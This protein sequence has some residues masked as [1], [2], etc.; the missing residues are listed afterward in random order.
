MASLHLGLLGAGIARSR[1]PRLQH[2][3]GQLVNTQIEYVL[4]DGL[5]QPAFDAKACVLQAIAD[6]FQGLNVTHPYKQQIY[7]LVSSPCIPA[8]ERIG[9]Y[10]TLLFRGHQILGANTDYSGFIRAYLNKFGNRPPGQVFLCGAGGV[11]RAVAMGLKALGCKKIAIFDT[12]LSQAESL[13]GLLE[14]EAVSV[15][16]VTEQ[17]MATSVVNADGLV[18]CTA[19]GMYHTPGSAIDLALVSKQQWAFDAVYTPLDTLFMTHC[20]QSGIQC[21]SGFDLWF[22]Q[23]LDAFRLFTGMEIPPTGSLKQETLSWLDQ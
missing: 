5:N 16:L 4:I 21:L 23:G 7:S 17:T 14:S 10:N 12:V 15:T 19:L 8:H 20:Q 22:F 11:G 1:M 3:L 6:G 9:S 13:A 2:Y 18:N